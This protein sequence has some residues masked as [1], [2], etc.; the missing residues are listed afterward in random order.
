[1]YI[2]KLPPNHAYYGNA[3]SSA[4]GINSITDTEH[5]RKVLI[6]RN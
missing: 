4:N 1:M 2:I 6:K 5:S 3:K